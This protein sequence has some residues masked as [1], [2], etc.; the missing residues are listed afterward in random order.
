MGG[1]ATAHLVVFGKD[2]LSDQ[3]S[4]TRKNMAR[5]RWVVL[6]AFATTAGL[7]VILLGILARLGGLDLV[8]L[9]AFLNAILLTILLA[10]FGI[11]NALTF[12][13]GRDGLD[14]ALPKLR[15]LLVWLLWFATLCILV[16]P[17]AWIVF[18]AMGF[19]I[20]LTVLAG[21]AQ[22]GSGWLVAIRMGQHEQ[23]WFNIKTIVRVVCLTGLALLFLQL[24]PQQTW[25]AFGLAFLI[26]ALIETAF[27]TYLVWADFSLRGVRAE[28][29]DV[30][31]LSKGFGFLSLSQKALDPLARLLISMVAGPA[32]LG[33]FAVARR[34]PM[35]VTQ[36]VSQALRALLPGLA[37]MKGQA[38]RSAAQG[39][40]RDA[41]AVQLVMVG[42]PV[43]AMAMQ[44]DVLF[45]VWLGQSNQGL[46]VSLQLMSIGIVATAS[47]MP[48]FWAIQ[49]FGDASLLARVTFVRLV[50]TLILGGV[51]FA[52]TGSIEV[53]AAAFSLFQVMT[54]VLYVRLSN[55]YDGLGTAIIHSL[56]KWTLLSFFTFV[57]LLNLLGTQIVRDMQ[58]VIAL[59]IVVSINLIVAGPVGLYLVK[60]INK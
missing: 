8:G 58:P 52:F 41:T 30:I 1:L 47:T 19:G 46:T 39:L 49:A 33:V 12:Q 15:T 13:I 48:L 54:A 56:P 23:Y 34:F 24:I 16:S 29:S 36:A 27:T 2:T 51:A 25:I 43:I 7:N 60:R 50:L 57:V 42:A 31:G 35:V 44:A 14:E 28:L 55:R 17:V 37:P 53:F 20:T 11:T 26:A 3:E 38:D 32:A 59:W 4:L 40:L 10:D 45:T 21:V 22:L 5:S 6:I 9:W 18:G